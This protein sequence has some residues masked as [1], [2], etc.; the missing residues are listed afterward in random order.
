MKSVV[1][2]HWPAFELFDQ[3]SQMEWVGGADF[4]WGGD[5]NAPFRAV[6][7]RRMAGFFADTAEAQLQ[8]LFARFKESASGALGDRNPQSDRIPKLVRYLKGGHLNLGDMIYEIDKAQRSSEPLYREL[9]TSL[10]RLAPPLMQKW[11]RLQPTRLNE[12]RIRASHPGGSISEADAREVYR[13]SVGIISA[14]VGA[15]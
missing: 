7:R 13:L 5:Q 2:L 14:S 15:P 4:L 11:S 8:S 9:K 1:A 10:T 6:Q 3:Q 12:L